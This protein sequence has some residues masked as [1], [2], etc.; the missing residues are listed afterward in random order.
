VHGAVGARPFV[1]CALGGGGGRILR[2][3]HDL[4]TAPRA[5]A[6]SGEYLTQFSAS[7]WLG[8]KGCVASAIRILWFGGSAIQERT[9]YA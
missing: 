7:S 8:P 2:V 4:H 3:K 5:A 9:G 1:A 6:F